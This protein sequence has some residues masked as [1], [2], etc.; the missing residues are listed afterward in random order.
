MIYFTIIASLTTY[1]KSL[2]YPK[3]IVRCFC[4]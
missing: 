3:I 2:S 4:N 1:H